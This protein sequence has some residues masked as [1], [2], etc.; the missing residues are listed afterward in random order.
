MV[1]PNTGLSP[2]ETQI[3]ELVVQGRS[4]PEIQQLLGLKRKT[5]TRRNDHA[6]QKMYDSGGS[7]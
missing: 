1:R 5:L 6:R 4:N 2:R 7:G 3:L